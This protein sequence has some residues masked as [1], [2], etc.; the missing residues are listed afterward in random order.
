MPHCGQDL[1]T[2]ILPSKRSVLAGPVIGRLAH[3]LCTAIAFLHSHN[4]YHLDIKP[5]NLAVNA[6]K[7]CELTVIDLGWVMSARQPCYVTGAAGTFGYV[8]PE[9]QKWLDWDDAMDELEDDEEEPPPPPKYNPQKAD[10]WA[11]GNVIHILIGALEYSDSDSDYDGEDLY[12]ENRE[13]LLEFGTWVMEER[14]TME[15]A[16]ERL[17]ALEDDHTVPRTP[18]P[19]DSAV[20]ALSP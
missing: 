1:R 12:V 9:V 18:S 11:I 13:G 3:Q 10:S 2:H 8:A 17:R 15:L 16:L 5:Q 19:V 14:P 6:D 7:D 4:M 20:V